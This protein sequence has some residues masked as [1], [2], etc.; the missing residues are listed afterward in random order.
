MPERGSEARRR[1]LPG[2]LVDWPRRL[3]TERELIERVLAQAPSR[4]VLDLGCGTG[5]HSRF[6]AGEGAEVVAIDASE[7][8]LERAQDEPVPD[9]VQFLL[10]DLGAV[11]RSVHGHFGAAFCLGNTLPHLLSPESATRMLIGLK[12]RLLPGAPVL[13]QLLNYDRIFETEEPAL[14]VEVIPSPQGELVLVR[15]VRPRADGIVLH[16][17]AALR[18]RPHEMPTMEVVDTDA[19]QLRGWRRAEL[20][21]MLDVARL[22]TRELYGDMAMAPFDPHT[23]MELVMVVG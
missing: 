11:E 21:T 5:D 15:L 19:S 7:A 3:A 4:R 8:A 16:T 10:T 14:P 9:G 18:H 23:S 2:D 17:T 12:R 20:E 1:L 22:P 13:L 6:L